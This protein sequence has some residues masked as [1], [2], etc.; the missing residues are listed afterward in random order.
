MLT[1]LVD[2]RNR[3]QAFRWNGSVPRERIDE[4]LA[5]GS[6][7]VPNDLIQLWEEVGGGEL[8][9]S[10]TVF[11]PGLG[12]E[13]NIDDENEQLVALGLPLDLLVFHRG[14]SISAIDQLSGEIVD[15][16]PESFNERGRFKT[17]D[18]WYRDLIRAEYGD[19]YG[20]EPL[21]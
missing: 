9:E 1:V 6:W 19:R 17:F 8:F 12:A 18:E 14:L 21:Q 2:A 13:D 11:Q 15:L 3:P 20:L 16:D 7:K 4:W 10:E 5:E